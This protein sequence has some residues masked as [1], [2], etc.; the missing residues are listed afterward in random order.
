[1][2]VYGQL[3]AAAEPKETENEKCKKEQTGREPAE[4]RSECESGEADKKRAAGR[5][6]AARQRK[7]VHC[8]FV[9]PPA[10]AVDDRRSS[11]L[12]IKGSIIS[13]RMR[14]G[15]GGLSQRGPLVTVASDLR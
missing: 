9:F 14:R 8:I 6:A 4:N 11:R 1:M 5:K 13:H 3:E 7:L 12:A 10:H 15:L 2:I